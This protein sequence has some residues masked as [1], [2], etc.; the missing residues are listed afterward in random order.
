MPE[1]NIS[2]RKVQEETSERVCKKAS[3]M[4]RCVKEADTMISSI[5]IFPYVMTSSIQ[6]MSFPSFPPHLLDEDVLNRLE[7]VGLAHRVG[8]AYPQP[9]PGAVPGRVDLQSRH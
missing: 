5:H 4:A 1:C 7:Q 3:F 6:C 9:A 8:A 2:Q